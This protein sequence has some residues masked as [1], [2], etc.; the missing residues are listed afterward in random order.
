VKQTQVGPVFFVSNNI[1]AANQKT[2][3]FG[4]AAS[5]QQQQPQT[6]GFFPRQ[7]FSAHGTSSLF[8][9]PSAFGGFG[10]TAPTTGSVFGGATSSSGLFGSAPAGSSANQAFGGGFGASDGS[11]PSG[12]AP[13]IRPPSP[14]PAPS[15]SFGAQD[16]D[17][18][19]EEFEEF[20]DSDPITIVTETPMAIFFSVNGESNI[21]SDGVDHQVSVAVLPFSAKIS[22]VA[23]PRMD[24]RVF[25]Q[26]I[27]YIFKSLI[28]S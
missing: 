20:L 12:A 8:N 5:Q 16:E 23:I 27:S 15:A 11:R 18:Q 14:I 26:V 3:F 1:A 2:S 25:L 6:T 21:P 28:S 22:Y 19:D 10:S 24:P 13:I 7:P 17:L 4:Q 9:N